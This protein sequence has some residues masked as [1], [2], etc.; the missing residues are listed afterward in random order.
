MVERDHQLTRAVE[1]QVNHSTN[2]FPD[3]CRND[4]IEVVNDEQVQLRPFVKEQF[5]RF[6]RKMVANQTFKMIACD[7]KSFDNKNFLIERI[8]FRRIGFR[9]SLIR[10]VRKRNALLSCGFPV[11]ENPGESA[12]FPTAAGPDDHDRIVQAR[13][14][15]EHRLKTVKKKSIFFSKNHLAQRTACRKRCSRGSL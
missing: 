7:K 15:I 5:N 1:A 14:L 3:G 2:H 8:F 11:H 9:E 6:V 13:E 10:L 12:S 4:S